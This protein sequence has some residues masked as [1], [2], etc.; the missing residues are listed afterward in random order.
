[1]KKI[2][3]LYTI[4]A[5]SAVCA[6][7]QSQILAP[8]LR[9][10]NL[11]IER[12]EATNMVDVAFRVIVDK[13]AV[14]SSYSLKV[15]PQLKDAKN[16]VDL[17]TIEVRGKKFRLSET[18]HEMSGDELIPES[19]FMYELGQTYEYS[20]SV[21]WEEWMSNK[22]DFR[23]QRSRRGCCNESVPEHQ[24][25]LSGLSLIPPPPPVVVAPE[26]E[27]VPVVVVPEP[28]APTYEPKFTVSYVVPEAEEVK[29]RSEQV[30][31]YLEFEVAKYD[32]LPYF[33]NNNFEL[34][35]IY[36]LIEELR[37]DPYATVTGVTVKGYA[38]PEASYASNLQL[39]E[40]RALAL[41]YHIQM[42]YRFDERLIMARG[43][44]EDWAG[45]DSLVSQA[46]FLS[47]KYGVLEVIR[48][49]EDPDRKENRLKRVS[50]GLPYRQIV[51]EF[52]PKLRRSDFQVHYSVIPFT[53]ETGREVFKTKPSSLSLNEMFLLAQE[54]YPG[55]AEFNEIFATAVRLFPRNDVA[56]INAAAAAMEQGDIA[57]AT[58]YLSRVQ[59]KKQA[60][61]LN[62]MGILYY[63]QEDEEMA[64]ECFERARSDGNMEARRNTIEM[65]KRLNS[66]R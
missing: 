13:K 15:V 61:Y 51:A 32:I 8:G 30:S 60:A 58:R 59:D 45:L 29:M 62:N 11:R 24:A 55:E 34:S 63:L 19:A 35:K 16:L 23:A 31:A 56:N 37:N 41:K 2:I 27:P 14:K 52:Y 43:L 50:R 21:P 46:P 65:N 4:L 47:D 22:I 25:L 49:Y 5:C 12:N 10:Q 28:V 20:A 26:P 33:R 39:S 18:R 42:L 44:G 1:M 66:T 40:R 48:S 7:A 36:R 3:L 57:A 64:M 6:Q 38:S 53:V 9:Y 17:P 54:Y